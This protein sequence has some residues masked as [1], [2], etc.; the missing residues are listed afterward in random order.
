MRLL[1]PLYTSGWEDYALLDNGHGQKLERWG[2]IV[3]LRPEIQAVG[4]PGLPL[5]AWLEQAHWRFKPLGNHTGQWEMLRTGSVSIWD[6]RYQTLRFGL[7]LTPSRHVGLFPEQRSNWDFI[8][9]HL[10]ADGRFLNLFAY[11]GAASCVARQTGA[12]TVHVDSVRPLLGWARHNMQNSGL[13]DIHWVREDAL[14]FAQREAKRGKQYQGIIMDPPAWG[15]GAQGEKWQLERKLPLLLAT[16]AQL[17]APQGFLIVN[18]YSPRITLA[19]LAA[20]AKEHFPSRRCECR[21]LWLE[22]RYSKA[23]YCGNVLRV[24]G[25]Y[26]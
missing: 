21:E 11:T 17:L 19:G 6:I 15:L 8:T 3:T 26:E 2:N 7:Q 9:Q 1:T 18:T 4:E 10:P 23:L 12:T 16:A 20:L 24:V 22:S 25:E 5:E 14:V 13:A